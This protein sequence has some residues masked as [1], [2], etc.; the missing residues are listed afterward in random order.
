MMKLEL[1]NLNKSFGTK[2]LQIT[3]HLLLKMEYTVF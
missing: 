2:K 3:F 1:K